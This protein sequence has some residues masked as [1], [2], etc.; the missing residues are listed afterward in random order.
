[1]RAI[2]VVRLRSV[3]TAITAKA[4]AFPA[5]K[6]LCEYQDPYCFQALVAL[7]LLVSLISRLVACS[8]RIVV[9]TQTD[10][11]TDTQTDRQTDRQTN[12]QIHRTTT[13]T[14]AAHA[15][16]GLI[17]AW[18]IYEERTLI[19]IT[20]AMKVRVLH[21]CMHIY[22]SIY[23]SLSASVERSIIKLIIISENM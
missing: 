13:V 5:L 16:G 12:R 2:C 20:F 1:M 6:F 23:I 22:L 4:N 8:A 11:Q 19:I 17:N 21:V 3:I 15:C 10:R 14:L 18:A 9:D 7:K